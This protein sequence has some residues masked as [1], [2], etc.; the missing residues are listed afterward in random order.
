[1]GGVPAG[2]PYLRRMKSKRL[3][4]HLPTAAR[5]IGPLG[6]ILAGLLYLLLPIA[7]IACGDYERPTQL[8]FSGGRL[9]TGV[10]DL[11]MGN[12]EGEDSYEWADLIMFAIDLPRSLHTLAITASAILA[13][14]ALLVW[15]FAADRL[16]RT[17]VGLLTPVAAGTVIVVAEVQAIGAL[18]EG[19]GYLSYPFSIDHNM[20]GDPVDLV[21]TGPGFWL[22]LIVLALVAVVMAASA[23]IR[24]EVA[25]AEPEG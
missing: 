5:Y 13:L 24:P 18:S 17:V 20:E 2:T 10:L 11:N 4:D 12:F 19:A 8:C 21:A 16:P 7:G 25:E 9:I 22:S 15:A 6:L 1:M 14:G 3:L 23:F